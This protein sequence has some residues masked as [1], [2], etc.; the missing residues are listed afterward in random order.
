MKYL[1]LGAITLSV[2]LL[3]SACGGGGGGT[4]GGGDP[5]VAPPPSQTAFS[6]TQGRDTDAIAQS[7]GILLGAASQPNEPLFGSVTQGYR[8]RSAPVTG[9][10]ASF[11]GNRF[12]LNIT[13]Q[14]GS[15]TTLDTDRD[16]VSDVVELSSSNN[17]V[18]NRPLVEGYIAKGNG[19]EYTAAAVAVEWTTNDYTDYLSGGYWLHVDTGAQPT[20]EIGAFIDGPAFE[21]TIQVPPIGTATY[22]GRA[23]GLYLARYG[24]DFP[25]VPLGTLEQGQY[26][27]RIRLTADFGANQVSG[28]IDNIG[29]YNV[30]AVTPDGRRT[31]YDVNT[32]YAVILG[33]IPIDQTGTFDGPG[34]TLT[35]PDL[36]IISSTGSWAGRFSNVDD[37]FGNPRAVAGTNGAYVTTAGGSESLFTGAFYGAT[38]RFP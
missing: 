11:N 38:E 5:I 21:E 22:N 30:L 31:A 15:S 19:S 1:Q 34:V 24:T 25:Q 27:G 8:L 33:A 4:I 20:V 28:R 10:N 9:L 6:G 32:D 14:D 17:P 18:T 36:Q 37:R 2:G 29:L 12:A 35:H 3:L 7:S 26:R 16:I 13:R 23:D